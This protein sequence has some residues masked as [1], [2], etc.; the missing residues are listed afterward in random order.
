MVSN[1]RPVIMDWENGE[2]QGMPLWDL[3]YFLRACANRAARRKGE[4]DST[5]NFRTAFGRKSDFRSAM[6]HHISH[7]A[8]EVGIASE[9]WEPLWFTCWMH[10]ALKEASMLAPGS[11]RRGIYLPLLRDCMT[12]Q[13]DYRPVISAAKVESPC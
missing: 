10:R 9:L 1:G 4:R 11:Q 13:N 6:N 2:P 12:Y 5:R 7:Y 8:A 3:F